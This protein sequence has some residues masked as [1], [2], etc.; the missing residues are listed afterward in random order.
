MYASAAGAV[1]II[2]GSN[3][4]YPNTNTGT[5]VD[6]VAAKVLSSDKLA[7]G[8]DGSWRAPNHGWTMEIRNTS[9]PRSGEVDFMKKGDWSPAAYKGNRWWNIRTFGVDFYLNDQGKLV[10]NDERLT[11]D[12]KL[13]VYF[14]R[15]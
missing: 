1:R 3:R 4:A 7:S 11:R 14:E 12:Y 5:V 2:W 8:I 9:G 15:A 10:H 6:N 13:A